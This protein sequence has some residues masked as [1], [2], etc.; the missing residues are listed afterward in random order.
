MATAVRVEAAVP[1]RKRAGTAEHGLDLDLPRDT[2]VPLRTLIDAVVRSEVQAFRLRS[3]EQRFVRVLTERSLADGIERGSFRSGGQSVGPI[4]GTEAAADVDVEEAV[5]AAL[6]AHEDGLYQVI[7][8]DE[9]VAHLDS[10][11]D[12]R[13]DSRLLFLRLVALAGG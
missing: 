7:V 13:P 8:D 3:E 2:S 6:L 12:L 5:A 11:V 9:P 4:D 1:G 10:R